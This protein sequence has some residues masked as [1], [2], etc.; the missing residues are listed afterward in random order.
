MDENELK[1]QDGLGPTKI[2][3]TWFFQRGEDVNDVFACSEQ[4]AWGLLRNRSNWM[5]RDFKMIGV[6][7]GKTYARIM[8]QSAHKKQALEQKTQQL[9]QEITRYN[10][11]YDKFKFDDLL[12]DEDPKMIKVKGILDNL[13]AEYEKAKAEFD[14]INKMIVE[15]AFKAELDVA[16]GKL[17]M[18][19]NFDVFTPGASKRNKILENLGQ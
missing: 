10:K 14:N 16:R 7:D 5:R 6:S 8:T 13:N 3:K 19:E 15:E 9:A 4:E 1:T 12:D 2:T 18:P 17:E 11:T